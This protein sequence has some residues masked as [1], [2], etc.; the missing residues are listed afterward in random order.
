MLPSPS[1]GPPL[2]S[3]SWSPPL[4][5]GI[6][7]EALAGA[8]LCCVLA[9]CDDELDAEQPA[10]ASAASSAR[11]A[12]DRC[13]V[14]DVVLSPLFAVSCIRAGVRSQRAHGSVNRQVTSS[15]EPTWGA[16]PPHVRRM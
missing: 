7:P 2:L 11:P 1:L 4:C 15:A 5:C 16:A 8:D 9:G 12:S 13:S 3:P 14:V 6:L 10:A